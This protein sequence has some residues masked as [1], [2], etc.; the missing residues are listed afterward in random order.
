VAPFLRS[1][2]EGRAYGV[3]ISGLGV[4]QLW[5][6]LMYGVSLTN[7]ILDTLNLLVLILYL[8][9]ILLRVVAYSWKKYWNCPKDVFKQTQNRMEFYLI[10]IPTLLYGVTRFDQLPPGV[11]FY[12]FAPNS[13]LMKSWAL[14]LPLFRLLATVNCLRGIVIGLLCTLPSKANL[15]TVFLLVWYMYAMIGIPLM[16]NQFILVPNFFAPQVNFDSFASSFVTLFQLTMVSDW[17]T[18]MFSAE[19]VEI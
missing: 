17:S 19:Q 4:F 10:A 11:P 5:V 14:V 13:S 18:T 16:A 2:V 6:C 9:D 7:D 12:L 15:V 3:F 1:F 8:C